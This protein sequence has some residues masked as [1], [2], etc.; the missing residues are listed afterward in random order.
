M[1]SEGKSIN[2]NDRVRVRLTEAGKRLIVDHVDHMNE[3]LQKRGPKCTFRAKVPEWD[4]DG[5][6]NEQFHTLM[7]YFG[8]CWSLGSEMP[9]TEMKRIG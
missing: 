5:W 1:G 2:P 4:S 9:F 6:I 3:W 7:G 8:D